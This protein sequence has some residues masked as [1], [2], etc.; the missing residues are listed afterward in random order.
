LSPGELAELVADH[1]LGHE[2][3]HVLAT[4]VHGDGQADHLRQYHRAA[5][6]GL[7]RPAIVLFAGD[8]DLPR[9]VE[10]DERALLERA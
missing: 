5:R 2:D 10:V 7:D 1:V 4:V 3:R 9:E 8:L 6:P